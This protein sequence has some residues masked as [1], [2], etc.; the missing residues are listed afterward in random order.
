MFNKANFGIRKSKWLGGIFVLFCVFLQTES[1]KAQN[2]NYHA[3]E[4]MPVSLQQAINRGLAWTQFGVQLDG[5]LSTFVVCPIS[6][7]Q[8]MTDDFSITIEGT[9]NT[10]PVFFPFPPPAETVCAIFQMDRGNTSPTN[11]GVEESVS[12]NPLVDPQPGLGGYP[13]AVTSSTTVNFSDTFI[14]SDDGLALVCELAPGS[15]IAH[16]DIQQVA[17]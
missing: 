14:D 12:L 7:D 1:A 3:S 5:S 8:T 11:N 15:G 10:G 2:F 13:L 16:W 9:F 17:P 6:V 4:C